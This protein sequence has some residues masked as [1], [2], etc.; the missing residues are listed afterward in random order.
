MKIFLQRI[1]TAN[2]DWDEALPTALTVVWR[3]NVAEIQSGVHLSIPRWFGTSSHTQIEIHGFA[4]A[5]NDALGAAVYIRVLSDC[6]RARTSLMLAKTRVAPMKRTTIA[7]L[8]LSATVLLCQITVRV[9]TCLGYNEV[10]VYLWT[11]SS[12]ALAWIRGDPAK[13]KEFVGN[14]VALIHELIPQARWRHVPGTENPADLASRGLYPREL[15]DNRLWWEGPEWL[16]N[17]ASSWPNDFSDVHDVVEAERRS[18]ASSHAACVSEELWSLVNR[19]SSF[20]KLLRVT[21]R[22]KRPF[23]VFRRR[24]ERT[25]F[26][27]ELTP[28]E[29]SDARKFWI[30]KVQSAH[31]SAEIRMLSEKK[32][33]PKSSPLFRLHPFVDAEGLVRLGGRLQLSPLEY[34][35]R[36]PLIVPKFSEISSLLIADC[37]KRTLHGGVQLTLST[38]RQEYWIIGGRSP[39]RSFILRCVKCAR[40]RGETAR[41]LMGQLPTVRTAPS[42][43]FLHAGVDYAGPFSLKSWRGRSAKTY[44]A[45]LI[46]FVC[47]ATSACH[48]EL[49]T[50][51]TTEGFLA[52]YRRFA[53]RRGVCA[54]IRSDCGTNLVGADAELK[55]LF[56][57]ASQDFSK[58]RNLLASDGTD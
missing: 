31:F 20:D 14:R 44:K 36:H 1:W 55:R 52:A 27:V 48:L 17:S 4:D 16:Q 50:D 23:T 30:R 7:R 24:G 12:V 45:Y 5:S 26:S 19:Y 18:A 43:P 58:L 49:A 34:D 29:L 42:R 21:A 25:G 35:S 22:L 40:L 38:L 28:H 56:E 46:V 57:A 10:P 3:E 41:Q 51:Y 39:V 2:L 33:I 47:F 15:R 53:G 32:E 9:L 54:T 37:H 6:L 11:D 8:E 13:W